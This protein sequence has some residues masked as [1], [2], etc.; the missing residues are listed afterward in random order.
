MD[1]AVLTLLI[2]VFL[3]MFCKLQINMRWLSNVT[4]NI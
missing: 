2:V 1:D 4:Y 3:D